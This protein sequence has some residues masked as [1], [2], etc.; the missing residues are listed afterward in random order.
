MAKYLIDVNLPYRFALWKG[1]DYVHQY[2]INDEST[3]SEIWEYA[4][5][6]SLTIVTKDA[7]FSNRV[8]RYAP[9]PK[10]IHIR[11]GNLKMQEFFVF[12]NGIWLEVCSLSERHKLVNVFRDRIEAIE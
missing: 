11:T 3:D 8:I 1:E 4:R 9:P 12:I 6:R 5:E 7:D 10:V 2:D